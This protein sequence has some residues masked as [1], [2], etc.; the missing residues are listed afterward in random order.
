MCFSVVTY[1]IKGYRIKLIK[2]PLPTRFPDLSLNLWYLD[3]G[4]HTILACIGLIKSSGPVLTTK[5]I[6][7]PR[8]IATRHYFNIRVRVFAS[9]KP[10]VRMP[11]HSALSAL[12]P[13]TFYWWI[14]IAGKV[15]DDEL[16]FRPRNPLNCGFII[17]NIISIQF[18]FYR[19]EL[20]Y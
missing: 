19:K 4:H 12:S 15:E 13:F 11:Q 5:R 20:L 2:E 18:Q 10:I 3:D 1:V 14:L 8:F 6:T 17:L 16:P 7:C 9:M